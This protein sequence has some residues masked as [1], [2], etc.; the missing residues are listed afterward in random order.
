[1]DGKEQLQI[2]EATPVAAQWDPIYEFECDSEIVQDLFDR[3]HHQRNGSSVEIGSL[4]QSLLDCGVTS[5]V[6]DL[7]VASILQ[8]RKEA[9]PE[10]LKSP[11]CLDEF[12]KAFVS[13][14]D[15]MLA[16]DA[17][18]EIDLDKNEILSEEEILQAIRGHFVP[19]RFGAIL[20]NY[21]RNR[22]SSSKQVSFNTFKRAF[23]E[24]PR[25][26]GARLYFARSLRLETKLAG[27]LKRGNA[28]DGLRGLKDMSECEI[29]QHINEVCKKFEQHLSALLRKHLGKLRSECV[30]AVACEV[31]Y[32]DKVI[33]HMD[34]DSTG[35]DAEYRRILERQKATFQDMKR[36]ISSR[37]QSQFFLDEDSLRFDHSVD[38]D[39]ILLNLFKK[40]DKQNR[41]TILLEELLDSE[42]VSNGSSSEFT[43]ILRRAFECGL[44]DFEQAL[45][46]LD[47]TDFGSF[48][49][50]KEKHQLD[51]VPQTISKKSRETVQPILDLKASVS[52][53]YDAALTSGSPATLAAERVNRRTQGVSRSDLEHLTSQIRNANPKVDSCKLKLVQALQQIANS[54]STSKGE[55]SFL[56]FKAAAQR[57]PRVFG[58][59]MEWVRSL[60][61]DRAL[62][63]HLPAGSLDDGMQ[64]VRG[65]SDRDHWAEQTLQAFFDDVRRKFAGALEQAVKATGS[66]SA[67]EANSKFEGFVGSFASLE[68]FDAGAEA[69]LQLGYPNPVVSKGILLEHTEHASVTRIFVTP[70][71][72]IATCLLIE[73]WWAIYEENPEEESVQNVRKKAVERLAQ[74]RADSRRTEVALPRNSYVENQYLFP[75]EVGDSFL[76]TL[77][78]VKIKP[79]IENHAMLPECIQLLK[80]I[81]GESLLTEEEVARGISVLDQSA[82]SERMA[83]GRNVI[84]SSSHDCGGMIQ[85]KALLMGAVLPVSRLRAVEICE[86]LQTA[87][88]QVLASSG[89]VLA[90][91]ELCKIWIFSLYENITDL[92]AELRE[93]SIAELRS[94]CR[95]YTEDDS[96]EFLSATRDDLCELAVTWFIRTQLQEDFRAALENAGQNQSESVAIAWGLVTVPSVD[97][98]RGHLINDLVQALD[99][100]ERW[101]QVREWVSLYRG[102]IHGRRRMGLKGL[103]K[104]EQEKIAQCGLLREEVLALH[105]YTGPEFLVIN[106]ICRNFPQNVLNILKDDN[107][108]Q[109]STLCTTLFCISSGLKKLGR[110]TELPENRVVYR[111]LG[112]MLLPQQFWVPHGSPLWR[113]GVERAFLSTTADKN[114]A[115]FYAK[116]QGTVVEISVGRIQIGGDVSFLSMVSIFVFCSNRAFLKLRIDL[117]GPHD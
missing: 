77:V 95:A 50:Y 69:T 27:L 99:S 5:A 98:D 46:H 30:P 74:I 14:H 84:Q 28:F 112:K 38:D 25:M 63:R 80:Q 104:R 86:K 70:N 67:F 51:P 90:S 35:V 71:Y 117:G 106:A 41:G 89:S 68:D 52:A 109:S 2:I 37:C 82:C 58:Q 115:L 17:F 91:I 10:D 57:V 54:L 34:E 24:F 19:D 20:I 7:L 110:H 8:N 1:M 103:M 81:A 60:G 26:R 42:I 116:G 78:V 72:R 61:L 62:A 55:L 73:Y 85:S 75:G 76:E 108:M 29:E 36:V 66:R 114:V 101:Q 47:A 64:E 87:L 79:E 49:R 113:G 9:G 53:I 3:V 100:E 4:H 39:E 111:G 102:R 88:T 18:D 107:A 96:F 43:T 33:R 23:R 105:L 65:M 12:A 15:D 48:A 83:S 11:L 97:F 13:V 21:L 31:E 56:N 59:R 93:L 94:K 40:L 92:R 22:E 45:A 32:I 44:E 16:R 6:A